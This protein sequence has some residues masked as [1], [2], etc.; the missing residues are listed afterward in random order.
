MKRFCLIG[1]H[2]SH[3]LSAVIHTRLFELLGVQGRYDLRELSPAEAA[4]AAQRLTEEGYDGFN[5]TIPYK[6]VILPQ[7]SGLS[8]EAAAIGAVNTVAVGRPPLAQD[9]GPAHRPA[10]SRES[11]SGAP[12]RPS[13][14][15]P[16]AGGPAEGEQPPAGTGLYGYNTDYAGFGRMLQSA[17]IDPAGGVAA[18]LGTGG[19]YR[20]AAA[21]LLDCGV[22]RL[23]A[24]TRRPSQAGERARLPGWQ[25]DDRLQVIGYDTL[26]GIA[27]ALVVNATPVGMFPHTGVSP[28][29]E[30]ILSK[31]DAAADLIYNPRETEFLRL[32]RR[33]GKPA[34]NGLTMLVAQAVAAQEIWLGRSIDP[35]M[36]GALTAELAGRF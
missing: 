4:S 9:L 13:P 36:V 7:L 18:V 20:A 14:C 35:A 30:Q 6:E 24:V 31:F 32:A 11:D 8:P 34:V 22:K 33:A 17:G 19:A 23:Y 5:V 26:E 2:L 10:A 27:G 28:V 21:W 3:S 15:K 29:G 1:E 25:E 12:G 16:L